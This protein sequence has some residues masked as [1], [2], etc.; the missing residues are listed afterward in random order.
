MHLPAL[1]DF[2]RVAAAGSLGQAS[3]DSG[4]PKA[5]LSRHL[6]Q[7]EES[8]GVR[9]VERGRHALRLTA[10][11]RDLYQRT[12]PLLRDI[13]EAG[14][15]LADGSREPQGQLRVSAPLLFSDLF[16]GRLASQ[17]ARR[18][19]GV[20]LEWLASDRPFDLV[21]DALDVVIRVNPRPDS[22][23]VGRCFAYDRMLLVAPPDLPLPDADPGDPTPR[24]PAVAMRH[25]GD[26]GTWRFQVDGHAREVRPDYRLHLSTFRMVRAAVRDGIGAGLLPNSLVQEDLADSRLVVWG[27][28]PGRQ[29][30]LW[31]LHHSRRLVSPKVSAFVAFLADSFPEHQL[32]WPAP[33][34]NP[35]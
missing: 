10:D 16:G 8:L 28:Y 22:E 1:A 27:T 7:L 23:L 24:V 15:R 14:R 29:V 12:A 9:L 32:R 21:D 3:R 30:E 35:G 17:F 6:R 18:H 31:V 13:E 5:T 20:A 11:G 33:Q 26:T 25:F 2:H 19:A 4:R 34:E